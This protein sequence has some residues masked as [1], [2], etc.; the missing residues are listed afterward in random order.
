MDPNENTSLLQRYPSEE[1]DSPKGRASLLDGIF[2]LAK[3][4]IGAG[5]FALPGAFMKS[6]LY[7]GIIGL[8][9][10]SA[11]SLYTMIL[12]IKNKDIANQRKGKHEQRV[13]SYPDLGDAVIPGFGK[14]L[15]QFCMVLTSLGVISVYFIFIGLNLY[16]AFYGLF[17][18]NITLLESYLF[19]LPFIIVLSFLR[20]FKFLGKLAYLG[21]IFLLL[22]LVFTLVSSFQHGD[23]SQ[24]S[25]L[26][27]FGSFEEFFQLLGAAAFIFGVHVMIVPIQ[28]DMKQPERVNEV[29]GY[30]GAIVIAVNL[31]LAIIGYLAFGA[32]S[33][34]LIICNLPQNKFLHAIQIFL[35]LEL[36]LSIPLDALPA[37]VTIEEWVGWP[38][39]PVEFRDNVRQK[40]LRALL[41]LGSWGFAILIPLFFQVLSLVGSLPCCMIAFIIPP[42]FSIILDYKSK[43]GFELNA[44]LI[45][46]ILLALFGVTI[47]VLTTYSNI[48]DIVH[49]FKKHETQSLF[50][51]RST[52]GVC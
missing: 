20:S 16:S 45:S 11:I 44:K 31:P 4:S 25:S 47:L 9:L 26:K 17:N 52:T 35:S 27:Y 7:S 34:G 42:V 40:L 8:L 50:S 13:D 22:A 24:Y 46:N 30:A 39:E 43:S 29:F 1:E 10:I 36:L 37:A 33:S 15:I 48:S 19:V 41:I 12:T 49:A 51:S 14:A 5:S 2:T 21:S 23:F 18:W 6:G 38:L 32:S 28:Q 3:C